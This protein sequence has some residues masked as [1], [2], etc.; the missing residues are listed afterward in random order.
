M[1]RGDGLQAGVLEIRRPG[2]LNI[3]IGRLE[4]DIDI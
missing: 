3:Q 1:R 4:T 2:F